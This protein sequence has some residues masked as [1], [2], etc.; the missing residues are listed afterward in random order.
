M[1]ERNVEISEFDIGTLLQKYGVPPVVKNVHLYKRA[2][3]N[4]SF[5]KQN[6]NDKPEFKSKSNE[7]LEFLGDGILEMVTKF[8]LYKRFPKESEGFMTEKKINL[9]KNETI[10]RIALEIGLHNW[11]LLSNE[12]EVKQMRTNVKKLGCLFEA[13]IAAIFLD[14]GE[15]GFVMT[16]KWIEN[17]FEEHVDW[18][19]I[20]QNDDNYKNRL[21]II[22]QKEFRVTPH[23]IDISAPNDRHYHMAVYLCIGHGKQI[24][25]LNPKDAIRFDN[26]TMHLLKQYVGMN[27]SM[28]TSSFIYLGDARHPIKKK[29]E[30]LAS[31]SVVSM[32]E[33]AKLEF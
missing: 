13:F 9:V 23:Y 7:R 12:A 19:E 1:N 27:T 29:A 22:L 17:V 16:Q 15:N 10:G 18:S 24:H 8:Y 31:E 25:S 21:Q 26:L 33:V 3:V 5:T 28:N 2:F 30:Q 11:L 20:I 14:F 32:F 4:K 6:Q